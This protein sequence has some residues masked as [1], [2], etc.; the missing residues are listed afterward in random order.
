M[1]RTAGAE[2]RGLTRPHDFVWPPGVLL[3]PYKPSS[4][5]G[6]RHR[7]RAISTQLPQLPLLRGQSSRRPRREDELPLLRLLLLRGFS[8]SSRQSP[9]ESTSA[10]LEPS[11]VS[12]AEAGRI[13]PSF[14]PLQFTSWK[15][16]NKSRILM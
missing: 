4:G 11:C 13:F 5:I 9:G 15:R 3:S 16:G 14:N 8:S 6:N 1:N 7:R 2:P 10:L 12:S